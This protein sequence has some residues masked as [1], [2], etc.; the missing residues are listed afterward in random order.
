[1]DHFIRLFL[2]ALA[3]AVGGGLRYKLVTDPEPV[4]MLI[5]GIAVLALGEVFYQ[6]DKHI[7][8]RGQ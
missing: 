5:F 1:M 3:L 8:I 6:I 2:L 7:A 4:K